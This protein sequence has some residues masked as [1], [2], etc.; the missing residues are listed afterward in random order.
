MILDV[1]NTKYDY[2][3]GDNLEFLL[4]YGGIMSSSTSKYVSKKIIV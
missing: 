2:K 3:L 4:T 1:S